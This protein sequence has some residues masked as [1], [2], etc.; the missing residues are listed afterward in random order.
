[1]KLTSMKR[2]VLIL[3]ALAVAASASISCQKVTEPE[4]V[5]YGKHQVRFVANIDEETKTV[6]AGDHVNWVSTDESLFH[7]F[8]NGIPAT[9]ESYVEISDDGSVAT[10]TAIF[11]DTE[12]TEFTYTA[13]VGEV[14][15]TGKPQVKDEQTPTSVSFDPNADIL[16]A[17]P[18]TTDDQSE[19][20]DMQFQFKRLV[21]I[22]KMTIQGI[23]SGETIQKVE[24][25]GDKA[26][27]SSFFTDNDEGKT[28]GTVAASTKLLK[29][30]TNQD[31]VYFVTGPASQVTPTITVTTDK[32]TYTK[33]FARPI[34]F[35]ANTLHSFK[36]AF[37]ADNRKVADVS[38]V[39]VKSI[40]DLS[41]GDVIVLGCSK[42][43]KA[44][45]PM[46]TGKFLTS[47][48]ATIEDEV[49]ESAGAIPITLGKEG[50]AWTL[51]TDEGVIGA[52]AAKALSID[53]NAQGYISTWDITISTDGNASITSTKGGYG[54]IGYNASSPRFLNYASAQTAI[55]IY[56]KAVVLPKL[57]K[58]TINASGNNNTKTI[59]VEW[60]DV[61]NA[62]SYTVSC[63]DNSQTVG[64]GVQTYSFTVEEYGTYDVSVTAN[65]DGYHS[66]TS[67][68]T[69]EIKSS[70]PT[71]YSTVHTS[72]V[73]FSTEGGTSASLAK[74][75]FSES[76]TEYNAI[77]AGTGK[78]QGKCVVTIPEGTQT[79]HFHAMGWNG[80]TVKISVNGSAYDLISDTGVSGN[81]PFTLSSTNGSY[82]TLNPNGATSITFSV[83]EGNRFVLW[84]VNAK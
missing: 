36:V 7:V 48:D 17:K 1:M 9:E 68:A 69:I 61:Q 70:D 18:I 20:L 53:P 50:D 42:E 45:G 38:Y 14:N 30:N 8:E 59:T 75:K 23:Q 58:P 22:N 54:T 66:S 81:S 84:G 78:V 60:E 41:A 2:I 13:F 10:I 19:S 65:A 47:V 43:G 74:V 77:K 73:T 46:G 56:K 63:G 79:L 76:G 31:V 33:T 24:L 55:Q 71:D 11:P 25:L 80:E 57:A 52:T 39:L 5:N 26:F 27:I 21:S 28:P 35:T 49:L 6:L 51:T 44:A 83:T 37:S 15:S 82:F 32:A 12:E 62:T 40:N 16:I 67:T 4:V 64:T 29:I 3:S 34:D 72:N